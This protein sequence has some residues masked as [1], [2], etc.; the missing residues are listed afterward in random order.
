MV[1]HSIQSDEFKPTRYFMIN[2]A[3][4]LEAY[5]LEN[6]GTLQQAS[7]I[8][9]DWKNRPARLYASNWHELFHAMP[10]DHRNKL[11]WKNRFKEVRDRTVVC[12][13]YSPGEDV[14]GNT[15]TD[16]AAVLVTMW[17]QG[18]DFDRGAWKSQELLKGVD[19]TTSLGNLVMER[20]QA[21][22][23]SDQ[24]GYLLIPNSS[25]TDDQLRLRPFFHDFM[26]LDLISSNASAASAKAAEPKV[27]YDLLARGIPALSYAAG[28][29]VIKVFAGAN[30]NMEVL[31]RVPEVWPADGHAGSRSGRWIHSDFKN[32]ALPYVAK[33]YQAM[34][35]RGSLNTS[36]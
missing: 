9:N 1:S 35:D 26:E 27:Q 7:M 17:N 10:S 23:N 15:D 22:W 16:T 31:G 6:V 33:A 5:D 20:N 8:E 30:F 29:N 32:V 19:W 18:F 25:I 14:L 13:F 4:P 2:A 11:K 24:G 36:L 3:V 34:I 28:A 21:G 12:N